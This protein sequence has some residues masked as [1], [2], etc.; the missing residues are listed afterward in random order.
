M[1]RFGLVSSIYVQR[2]IRNYAYIAT[3]IYTRALESALVQ[4]HSAIS[5]SARSD[6]ARPS[7]LR[8]FCKV[9][10]ARLRSPPLGSLPAG[11]A[12][13]RCARPAS[14]ARERPRGPNIAILLE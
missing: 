1:F 8:M 2:A 6:S 9:T 14:G 13:A 11:R 4:A 3:L 10:A 12:M 5:M 7:A